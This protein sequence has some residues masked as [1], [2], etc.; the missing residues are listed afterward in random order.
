[1]TVS[2]T[3]ASYTLYHDAILKFCEHVPP[4]WINSCN[5]RN[6]VVLHIIL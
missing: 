4:M 6:I 5:V 2:S 3:F 1:M